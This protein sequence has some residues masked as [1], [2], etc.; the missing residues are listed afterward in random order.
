MGK[1]GCVVSIGAML[2][3]YMFILVLYSIYV[4]LHSNK[5]LTCVCVCVTAFYYQILYG[6]IAGLCGEKKETET[7]LL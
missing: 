2:R 4:T 3:K 7:S 1:T 6:I 5:I